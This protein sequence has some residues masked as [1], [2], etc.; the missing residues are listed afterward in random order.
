MGKVFFKFAAT[1]LVTAAA[2]RFLAS[3][4]TREEKP[5]VLGLLDL[6]QYIVVSPRS[7]IAHAMK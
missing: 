5:K 7:I 1:I 6:L 4:V 3:S 2:Q